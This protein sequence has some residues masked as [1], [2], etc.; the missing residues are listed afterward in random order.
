MRDLHK[1]VP[2]MACLL[3]IACSGSLMELFSE[4]FNIVVRLASAEWK[5]LAKQI[6]LE[7]SESGSPVLAIFT[8]GSL[9]AMLAFACPLENLTHIQAASFLGAGIFR[10]FYL[11]YSPFRPKYI[12][13]QGNSDNFH[14][15]FLNL[16]FFRIVGDSSLSYSR[17]DAIQTIK[18]QTSWRKSLLCCFGRNTTISSALPKS[19]SKINKNKRD[20]ELEREWLLLGEPPSS[21]RATVCDH[22]AESSI[23][24]DG[25]PPE[26]SHQKPDTESDSSTDIDAI[27]DEYRQKVKV[28][29]K[30]NE[31]FVPETYQ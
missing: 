25:D 21:P 5:I 20:E 12:P 23:L 14:R 4:M 19:K 7:N 9:C 11:I 30:F 3:V 6:G 2:A 26:C 31:Y 28:T 8:G 16:I 1:V 22:D 29:S 10:A 15:P 27:V 17:L 24:S 13:Q 18:T